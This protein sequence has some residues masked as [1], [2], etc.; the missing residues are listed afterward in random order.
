MLITIYRKMIFGVVISASLFCGQAANAAFVMTLDD[1]GDSNAATVISDAS[2][3][4][5]NN[6]LGVITYTGSVGAFNINVT[7]GV[8]KPILTT[9]G[10]DLNSI[11]VNGATPGTLRIGITDTDFVGD[12][13]ALVASYGGT[14]QGSVA[15]NYLLDSNN[16]E[17]GGVSFA[18]AAFTASAPANFSFSDDITALISSATP[19]SLTIWADIT[20]TGSFQLTSFDATIT[21]T[22]VPEPSAFLL[23]MSSLASLFMFFRRK[24]L[25]K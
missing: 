20:H 24:I 21:P 6:I 2:L 19:Y 12:F 16:T 23:Y 25:H 3:L 1:L 14:T 4:D 18:S 10:L 9:G 22:E 7:T 5:I 15:F 11:D 13:S 8:S 17:F